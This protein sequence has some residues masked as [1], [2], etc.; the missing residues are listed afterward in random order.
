MKALPDVLLDGPTVLP[1]EAGQV[2]HRADALSLHPWGVR[3]DASD[4]VRQVASLDENPEVHLGVH[5][6]PDAASRTAAHLRC[7][8]RP[9]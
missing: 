3:S 9:A 6:D 4:G 5:P 8:A 2:L 7:C 1:E